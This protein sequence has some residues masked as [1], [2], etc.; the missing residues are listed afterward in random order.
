VNRCY[1]DMSKIPLT[2]WKHFLTSLGVL[3][4]L[5]VRQKTL[6]FSHSD[7]V[8]HV[9]TL[10]TICVLFIAQHKFFISLTWDECYCP[11]HALVVSHAVHIIYPA[12]GIS[13]PVQYCETTRGL[14][15][16]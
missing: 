2:K 4:F 7:L 6:K 5:A 14:R 10:Y 16:H 3:E 12:A 9:G 13:P 11:V 8:R 15:P 1:L